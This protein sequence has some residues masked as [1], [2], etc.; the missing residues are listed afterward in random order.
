MLLHFDCKKLITSLLIP[1]VTGGASALLI[2]SDTDIYKT[3][4]K[5]PLA[6]PAWLFPVAWTLLYLLMG[7]SLYLIRSEK[8][9]QDKNS[10]YILFAL[11]LL[12]NFLWSPVFFIARAFLPSLVILILLLACVGVMIY[13]F[14]KLSKTA[15]LLQMPYFLWLIFAG[16]LNSAVYI[17]N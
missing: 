5:P 13:V 1:I 15:A 4:E 6:P 10:A 16:Y 9:T 14:C 7:I 8:T 17:L 2:R 3:L 11:Q 12:L